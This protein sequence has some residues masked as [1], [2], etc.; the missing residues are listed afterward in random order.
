MLRIRFFVGNLIARIEASFEALGS[1]VLSSK[2]CPM[3][4]MMVFLLNLLPKALPH[5]DA[6]FNSTKP[7][8]A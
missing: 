2:Y 8:T 6:L 5:Q 1:Q 4:L 7:M 3:P